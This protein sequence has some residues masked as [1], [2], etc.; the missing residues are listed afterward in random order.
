MWINSTL[1]PLGH[2]IE[3]MPDDLTD[4]VALC[5]FLEEVSHKKLSRWSRKPALRVHKIENLSI[6]L[7]FVQGELGVRLVGI[8][9]EG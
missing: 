1:E 5:L 7:K 2:K 6:A 3:V 8:G 9:P 4:G